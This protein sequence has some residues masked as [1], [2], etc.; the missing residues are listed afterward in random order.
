MRILTH[1]EVLARL[2]PADAV[3]A[4]R[5]A[6]RDGFDPATDLPRTKVPL[7]RGE[8]HILPASLPRVGGVKILAIQPE[9]H[10]PA[11]PLIQGQYL[12]IDSTT[13][14]PFSLLNGTALTTLRTPAVSVAGVRDFLAVASGPLKVV[15]FGTGA[16]G[17]G[18]AATV[19]SVVGVGE[20]SISFVGRSEPHNLGHPWLAAGSTE[21][22][23]T[24]AAADLVVCA[25][26]AREPILSLADVRLDA[27]I[28]A[29][30]SHTTDARELASDLMGAAHVM[31]EDVDAALREA[32][33]VTLAIAEG[34]L[35]REDLIP[36]KDVVAGAV[37]FERDRPIVFKTVGMPWEDLVVADAVDR[38]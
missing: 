21:A 24:V 14:T 25:T 32:G 11:L 26:T 31:V 12:L 18:H 9:D 16:Q 15:I 7:H 36:M 1:D 17:R 38:A 13:L 20:A 2:S 29:V 34:A 33:D 5:Q 6:L 22:R 3:E 27:L 23:E 37:K 35:S 8:M 28:I 19:E 4:L 10:D 30:G